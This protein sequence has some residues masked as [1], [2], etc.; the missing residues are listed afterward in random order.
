MLIG[1]HLQEQCGHYW[2]FARTTIDAINAYK[3][4]QYDLGPW[5]YMNDSNKCT[6][7]I[8]RLKQ[9]LKRK[10]TSIYQMVYMRTDW[11]SSETVIMPVVAGKPLTVL[12][13]VADRPDDE[14][15]LP[16]LN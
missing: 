8:Q 16:N 15:H 12:P 7:T 5:K 1:G 13:I 14:I 11:I 3:K 2:S 4:M 10:S 6:I 9:Y